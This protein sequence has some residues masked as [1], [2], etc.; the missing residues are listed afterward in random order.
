MLGG[1]FFGQGTEICHVQLEMDARGTGEIVKYLF[2]PVSLYLGFNLV[3][4]LHM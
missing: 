4:Y 3:E 2:L 1:G